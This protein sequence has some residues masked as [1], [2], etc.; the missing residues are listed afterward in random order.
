MRAEKRRERRREDRR[1]GGERVKET[2]GEKWR[3]SRVE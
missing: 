2:R 3:E 1:E